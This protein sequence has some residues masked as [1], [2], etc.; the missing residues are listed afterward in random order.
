MNST[1]QVFP[2]FLNGIPHTNY[3]RISVEVSNTVRPT[4]PQETDEPA[5]QLLSTCNL[6]FH[7]SGLQLRLGASLKRTNIKNEYFCIILSLFHIR[8]IVCQMPLKDFLCGDLFR[9][10][11]SN[12]YRSTT[13]PSVLKDSFLYQRI[14]YFILSQLETKLELH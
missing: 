1:F 7:P 2:E 3:K 8:K 12:S 11:Q 4:L 5:E 10:S 14:F 6:F 13:E 9:K